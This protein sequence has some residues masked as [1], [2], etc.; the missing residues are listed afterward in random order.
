MAAT[1]LRSTDLRL[2]TTASA[3]PASPSEGL[4]AEA[5]KTRK[6]SLEI[7]VRE[8]RE[9]SEKVNSLEERV[10]K[11]ESALV[12]ERGMRQGVE[13]HVGLVAELPD[14]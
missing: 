14:R 2:P 4:T 1:S 11:L 8:N 12:F 10:E 9:L 3:P 6:L 13:K 7:L 5:V